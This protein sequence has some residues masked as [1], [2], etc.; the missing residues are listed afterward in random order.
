MQRCHWWCCP[1]HMMLTSMKWYPITTM[2]VASYDANVDVNGIT[3]QKSHVAWYFCY[4]NV[5]NAVV[6][7]MML[8]AWHDTDNDANGIKYPTESCC[9]SFQLFWPKECSGAV[10]G[11]RWCWF[12]CQWHHM[13]KT[14]LLHLLVIIVT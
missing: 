11:I 3:W 5:K 10:F 6:S 2:P 12:W 9:T 8:L 13:A 7:F 14:V 1:P 4:F